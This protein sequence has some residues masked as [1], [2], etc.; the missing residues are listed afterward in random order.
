MDKGDPLLWQLLLLFILISID[1]LFSCAEISLLTLNKNKLE[2]KCSQGSHKA[3]RVFS[4]TQ[5]P[6]K[7]LA[8]VQVGSTLSGFLASAFAAEN[9]SGRLT[10]SLVSLGMK[11]PANILVTASL[12][13]ITVILS[14]FTLVFGELLPKRIALKNADAMA[15]AISGAV[16]VMSQTFAPLVW[17]LTKSTN[18]LLRIMGISTEAN[19][20]AV[21]EEEIRLMID[22]GSARGTIKSGE[23]EILNNVFE[24]DNK[25]AGEVMTHRRD[26]VLLRLEDSDEEWEKTIIENNHS[27]FPVCGKNSDD[28]TGVLK[29]RDYFCLK[30]RR[31]ETVMAH[32]VDPAQLVPTS[33]RTDVLFRRMK[34]TRRHFAVVLDEHGGMMGIVTIKDLLEELVG[35]LDDDISSPPEQPLIEKTGEKTWAVNGAL[36]LEKAA[37]EF[38]L[39]LP[40]ERYD[41]F[42]GFVFS[43]LGQIPEDGCQ[44]ELE[45]QEL[46]IKI[47]EIRERRLEK[48]LVIKTSGKI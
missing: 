30:D 40:V 32:A 12:V 44:A 47:L 33:V 39:P 8:T 11:I 2:Q 15:Y 36:S 34:K 18:L 41:T 1:A 10:V 26:T 3:K 31:R 37:R 6:A 17:L 21:T 9:L 29:S 5:Q 43:L 46:K 4:L 19:T 7:F 45:T 42:A 24:F 38:E 16:L 35:N 48:A 27:F 14:F 22:V 25:T 28:I 13:I 20:L 23:K